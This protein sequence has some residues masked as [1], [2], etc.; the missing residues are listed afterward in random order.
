MTF[1]GI[2]LTSRFVGVNNVTV[3]ESIIESPNSFSTK[4]LFVLLK[5]FFYYY[6]LKNEI[7]ILVLKNT[8]KFLRY[9]REYLAISLTLGILRINTVITIGSVVGIF[10]SFN[11]IFLS[12]FIFK[13]I[14]KHCDI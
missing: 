7:K 10:N 1:G 9:F 3:V 5:K 11:I 2:L 13:N 12:L 8:V 6:S 14:L 4:F